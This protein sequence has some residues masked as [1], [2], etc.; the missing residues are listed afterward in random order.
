MTIKF[1]YLCRSHFYA[2][3]EVHREAE[4]PDADL[5]TWRRGSVGPKEQYPHV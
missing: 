4:H 2:D 1:C 3:A 5:Y